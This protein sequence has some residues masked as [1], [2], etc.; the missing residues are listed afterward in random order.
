MP[1]GIV[2]AMNHPTTTQDLQVRLG[3]EVEDESVL[4]RHVSIG[5]RPQA[6]LDQAIV[7]CLTSALDSPAFRDV[8]SHYGLAIRRGDVHLYSPHFSTILPGGG[9][10][11]PAAEAA[12]Q[13]TY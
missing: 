4:L 3:V 6:D 9:L 12:D 7:W 13:L 5:G 1:R 2:A 8:L 11:H 10:E